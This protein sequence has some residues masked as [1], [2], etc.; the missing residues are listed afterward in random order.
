MS[1]ETIIDVIKKILDIAI[2]WG[3]FYAILKNI[4]N[5]V[6]LSLLFKGIIFI[7]LLK[8]I[9]NIIGLNTVGLL[10]EYVIEWGPLALIIIFQPEIRNIL[11]QIGRTQLLGRHKVL[12]VDEREKLVYELIQAIEYLRKSHIGALIVLERD[13]SLQDYI[14]KSINL[15]ADLSSELLIS[16]FFP[17]NPL[18]DGGVIIQ[19]DRISCAGAVFP[20]S[21][22][23]KLNKRLGTRHRAALGI[24]EETDAI[25][26]VVSEETSRIS[27]AVKGELYYNLTIDDARILLIDELKPK[28]DDFEEFNEE[29]AYN[30]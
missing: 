13:V 24:A 5:N 6:K 25:A 15:Y 26:I 23:S 9:S 18:H 30:E 14:S 19:G 17:N 21:N 11:E 3:L 12:T 2:V 8:L 10:L 4:K 20:T 28:Q 22:S 16:I 27:I 29:D 7:V 1:I